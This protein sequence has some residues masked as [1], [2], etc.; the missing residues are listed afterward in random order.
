MTRS[1][2]IEPTFELGTAARRVLQPTFGK[3]WRW[4]LPLLAAIVF[5]PTFIFWQSVAFDPVHFVEEWIKLSV[6]TICIFLIF[7]IFQERRRAETSKHTLREFAAVA[8]LKPLH[9]LAETLRSARDSINIGSSTNVS[10]VLAVAA[11]DIIKIGSA[12]DSAAALSETLMFR[13]VLERSVR[14]LD[15]AGLADALSNLARLREWGSAS[16]ADFD[17]VLDILQHSA[18][19][20]KHDMRFVGQLAEHQYD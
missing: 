10:D 6:T 9:T 2:Q 1:E 3:R 17:H 16:L 15:A 12:L 20:L 14:S 18:Q 13:L 7:E 8:V 4:S 11:T 5:L 19:A